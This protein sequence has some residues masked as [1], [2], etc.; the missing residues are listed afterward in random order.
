MKIQF[1]NSLKRELEDFIP[2]QEGHVGLYCCGPTVYNYAHIG[3]I[4]AYLFEDVL[5]RTLESAGYEVHHV[6]N[7]T[8]V[9]HLTDDGDEGED[10]MIKS[11]R[12]RGMSVWDIAAFFT[13]TFFKD[14]QSMNILRPHRVCKATDHIQEMIDLVKTLEEKGFT[15]QAG[16]NVYFDTTRFPNYGQ[17][18][19]L[20][21]QELQHGVRVELDQEKKNPRD[22]VLW[23][24]K[25]KFEDQAMTWPSPWGVGYPGWHLECSAMS[26]K[27]LGQ[28]FDIHC[29][30]IDHIPV[31][32]TNEIAQS[33]A[34]SGKKWVNY[35]LHN[36][37]ILIKSGKMSKSRGGFL[38]LGDLQERGYDP[39][40][41]RYFLLGG[42]YRSQLIFSWDSLD[43]ARSARNSLIR[44]IIQLQ[45][46]GKVQE[47]LSAPALTYLEEFKRHLWRDLNT[48]RGLASVWTLLKSTEISA[49]EK[50]TVIFKMDRILGLKLEEAGV[51]QKEAPLEKRLEEL[52]ARRQQARE[53]RDF[54]RADAIRDELLKE[55]IQLL[56]SADGVKWKKI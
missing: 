40:D 33:E 46:D 55:G 36:E 54:A 45:Q 13:E 1:V 6:M 16:G 37:F 44:R 38:T 26:S 56:D 2:L 23:F 31:H 35:W 15:Y 25:S 34:A 9:G 27:Y 20:A 52:I 42:H 3:N 39:L 49:G 50:L 10:K 47:E 17:M 29:G 53:Q 5:R 30:G 43:A 32:H 24:T 14:T 48:P 41:Y 8:D 11:A 18:A 51:S 12:E 4:R 28:Q 19:N 7:V 21:N 22:F